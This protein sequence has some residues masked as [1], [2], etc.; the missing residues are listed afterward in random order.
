MSTARVLST[1][2]LEATTKQ[3]LELNHMRVNT[4]ALLSI[5]IYGE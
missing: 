1:V 4:I 5:P 3:V 2:L